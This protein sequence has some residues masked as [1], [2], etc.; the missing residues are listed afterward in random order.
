MDISLDIGMTRICFNKQ[1][2]YV[3]GLGQWNH[4]YL[5][6]LR[7]LD[8]PIEFFIPN[9]CD[10]VREQVIYTG[11]E[12]YF[13]WFGQDEYVRVIDLN[14]KVPTL[15]T[16]KILFSVKK[17]HLACKYFYE[18]NGYLVFMDKKGKT[19]LTKPNL[20]EQRLQLVFNIKYP[21]TEYTDISIIDGKTLCFHT[22]IKSKNKTINE[23]YIVKFD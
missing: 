19:V 18:F 7:K 10:E 6:N 2:T 5:I 20:E 15:W 12:N 13:A 16:D 3:I 1:S 21:V 4:V 11:D 14:T 23:E 17:Y 8:A 9:S 22:P